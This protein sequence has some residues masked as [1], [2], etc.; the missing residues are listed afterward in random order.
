MPETV[1]KTRVT[2]VQD[3]EQNYLVKTRFFGLFSWVELSHETRLGK[4]LIIYSEE[5]PAE[6][7]VWSDEKQ[8][9]YQLVKN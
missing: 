4:K 7:I 1:I 8:E 2:E 5:P 3:I 6:I 9:A